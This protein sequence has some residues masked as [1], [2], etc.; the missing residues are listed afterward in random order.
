[1]NESDIYIYIYICVCVCVCVCVC[2]RLAE[3]VE[4]VLFNQ[5]VGFMAFQRL[6]GY[7]LSRLNKQLCFP[8]M[9]V[10]H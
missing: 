7:F 5:V 6:V 4:I 1:M 3:S 2:K 8:I 10:D 9:Y